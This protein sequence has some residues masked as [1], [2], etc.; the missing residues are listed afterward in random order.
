[1]S[2]NLVDIFEGAGP[3]MREFPD[4]NAVSGHEASHDPSL[5]FDTELSSFIPGPLFSDIK[6]E[7]AVDTDISADKGSSEV[8]GNGPSAQM[9]AIPSEVQHVRGDG[10]MQSNGI[11]V[12]SAVVGLMDG[13]DGL[14]GNA[15]VKPLEP[16]M[17]ELKGLESPLLS[18]QG[19]DNKVV[20]DKP[21]LSRVHPMDEGKLDDREYAALSSKDGA[22][23]ER[24]FNMSSMGNE[25]QARGG[26]DKGP[27]EYFSLSQDKPGLLH[28]D[29]EWFLKEVVNPAQQSVMP[30]RDT[31]IQTM[32]G[33]RPA[34]ETPVSD[35][36]LANQV[37]EK[38]GIVFKKGMSE[39]TLRIEPPELG[40]IK[41]DMA[42]KDGFVTTRIIVEHAAVKDA[43]DANVLLLKESLEQSGFKVDEIDIS[44]GN[45]GSKER[46]WSSAD[47]GRGFGFA[48]AF[49]DAALAEEEDMDLRRDELNYG[50]D[51]MV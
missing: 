15:M 37:G 45:E 18:M 27:D 11:S 20:E 7:P 47:E 9:E 39:A 32:A 46:A 38:I 25:S 44:L 34:V 21:A 28:G 33:I 8:Q 19:M 12:N 26:A 3:G 36:V 40:S 43:L 5:D 10:Y 48:H 51:I 13:P 42:I 50:V 17:D 2:L 6:P 23:I 22:E 16:S 35:E 31:G 30:V 29:S 14:A 24:K 4:A 49:E 41:I 1:M